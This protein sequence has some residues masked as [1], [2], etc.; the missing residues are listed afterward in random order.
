MVRAA[1]GTG[2]M[3]V[4][5]PVRSAVMALVRANQ[6]SDVR[7]HRV[8]AEGVLS[9]LFPEAL[10]PPL[11]GQLSLWVTDGKGLPDR[12]WTLRADAT[13]E[14]KVLACENTPVLHCVAR[15]LRSE[16][17]R[18]RDTWRGQGVDFP[19]CV[20]SACA[21]G[22]GNRDALDKEGTDEARRLSRHRA[23]L[24]AGDPGFGLRRSARQ[25][26][27]VQLAARRWSSRMDPLPPP[28]EGEE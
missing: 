20:S 17:Q 4:P 16:S 15:Q 6:A 3:K 13:F 9:V 10:P 21:Q 8:V 25:D 23:E 11:P 19:S 26:V 28:V 18:T 12:P 14:C 5:A 2:W 22:R 7:H 27:A 24:E 1:A